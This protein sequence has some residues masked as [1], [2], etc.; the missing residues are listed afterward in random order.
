MKKASMRNRTAQWTAIWKRWIAGDRETA[1]SM[2]RVWS[3]MTGE[4][5]PRVM[6]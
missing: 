2:A 5:L 4:P 6:S 1:L 3:R